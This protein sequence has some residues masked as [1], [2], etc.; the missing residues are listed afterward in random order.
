MSGQSAPEFWKKPLADADVHALLFVFAQTEAAL[1]AA[2]ERL[3]AQFAPG[4]A[5]SELAVH[6]G[7]GLPGNVAHFGY[8]DGFSQPAIEGGPPP[9]VPDVLPTAPPGEFLLGYQSQYDSFTYPMPQPGALGAE[10]E[11]RGVPDPRTG[12]RGVRTVP[13]RRICTNGT[14]PRVDCSQAMRSLA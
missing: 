13:G 8:R 10:R 7:R 6:D 5:F 4:L 14:R 12:L 3:R 1:E 9:V 2:S 11:L